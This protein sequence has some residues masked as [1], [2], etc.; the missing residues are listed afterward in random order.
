[1]DATYTAYATRDDITITRDV[2]GGVSGPFATIQWPADSRDDQGGF[3]L[4]VNELD[5]LLK[6]AGF[7]VI[8]SWA[9]TTSYEGLWLTAK[10]IP[11]F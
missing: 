4:A 2:R 3:A 8:D 9:I 6:S 10:V 5:A 1:M 11:N 7:Q